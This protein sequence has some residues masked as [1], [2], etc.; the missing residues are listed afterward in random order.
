[1]PA[2]LKRIANTSG[3]ETRFQGATAIEM[4]GAKH[5]VRTAVSYGLELTFVKVC[6][7][8]SSMKIF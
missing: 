5:E 6:V 7:S 1:M 8:T 4:H 2:V 3:A